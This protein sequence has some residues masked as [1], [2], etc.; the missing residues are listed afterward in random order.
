MTERLSCPG[1]GFDVTDLLRAHP[2]GFEYAV[3]VAL[4][5]GLPCCGHKPSNDESKAWARV[6]YAS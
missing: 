5:E 3:T 6:V 2:V 4:A 1:C